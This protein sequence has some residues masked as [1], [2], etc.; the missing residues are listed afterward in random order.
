MKM[1]WKYLKPVSGM[2]FVGLLIKSIGS[3]LELMLPYIL[4]KII[5]DIVPLKSTAL[6]AEWG[7]IMILCALLAWWCNIRA[8]RSA[9]EVSRRVTRSIRHDLFEKTLYLSCEKTDAFTI[10]SLETRLTS[11]T[12]N[13]HRMLGMMQRMG[14]KAPII[15]VGGLA[16]TLLMDSFLF[17]A[18]LAVIP[19]ICILVYVRA[20]KGVPLF[21]KVQQISDKMV[22]VVRENVQGI[23]VIKALSRVENEKKRYAAVNKAQHDQEIYA[24]RTMAIISP[25]MNLFLNLGLTG[26]ILLGAY[27]VNQGLSETGRIIAFM[28]YFTI[29]SRSMMAISRMFI[30]YSRGIASAN[31]IDE[32]LQTESEKAWKPGNYP[33]GDPQYAIEFR[34]VSF[35]YLKVKDNLKHISFKI[36]PGESLGI[37]GATGSGKTTVMSLLLHFYDIDSGAIYLNGKD[38]RNIEPSVLRRQFGLVMQND[39][40]FSDTIAENIRFGREVS[41]DSMEDAIDS[42]QASE[43]INQLEERTEHELTT[44]GTNVSGGQRQRILLSRAFASNPEFLLLDDSS[45]ALDYA[46]DAKLRRA[47]TEKYPDTTMVIIAQRVS[48]IRSCDQIMILDNGD[49]SDIGTDE[50]LTER[51]ALYASICDSQMGGALFE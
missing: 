37:L 1:I 48:S 23:R 18:L 20:T 40:L 15:V 45:S 34:D 30:M 35:S 21:A 17:L 6:I 12:Y 38:I 25:G 10:P 32:V 39:F 46:T 13:V 8:N 9:A 19:F 36:R 26:V 28:S 22:G 11:D 29:I 42:A 44:N 51:S 2:M 4:S 41:D 3:V 27:R 16:I 31:R 14:I 43:F 5:D 47:L 50:E 33:D 24:N 49:L 7:G